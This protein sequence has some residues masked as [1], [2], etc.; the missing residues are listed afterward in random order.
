MLST[1]VYLLVGTVRPYPYEGVRS[2]G[3]IT[4]HQPSALQRALRVVRVRVLLPR[5]RAAANVRALVGRVD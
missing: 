2:I 4:L 1:I 3:H 5:H